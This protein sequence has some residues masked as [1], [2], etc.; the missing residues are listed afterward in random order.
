MF[1]FFSTPGTNWVN[2]ANLSL[3]TKLSLKKKS[4]EWAFSL[5]SLRGGTVCLGALIGGM[6][7]Q[8]SPDIFSLFVSF[9]TS[10]ICLIGREEKTWTDEGVLW[11]KMCLRR[12]EDVVW[13]QN[14]SLSCHT[15]SVS[16]LIYTCSVERLHKLSLPSSQVS[17]LQLSFIIPQRETTTCYRHR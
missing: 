16:L 14:K 12:A 8:C 6:H 2:L 11:T 5:E 13:A 4:R 10:L 9:S 7:W 17:A 1:A 15:A 3:I